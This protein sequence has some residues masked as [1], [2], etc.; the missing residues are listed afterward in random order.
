MKK[1][2]T[3]LAVCLLTW[4]AT[5]LKPKTKVKF[6]AGT[7]GVCCADQNSPPVQLTLNDD[8]SFRYINNTNAAKPLN[9]KGTWEQKGNTIVLKD[10]DQKVSI[11]TKWKLHGSFNCLRSRKGLCWTRICHLGDCK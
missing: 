9:V 8:H 7:F 2:L 10:L 6:S 11:N 3:L 5:A 1:L 4:S